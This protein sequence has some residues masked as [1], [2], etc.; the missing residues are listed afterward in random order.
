MIFTVSMIWRKPKDQNSKSDRSLFFHDTS[1]R[2]PNVLINLPTPQTFPINSVHMFCFDDHRIRLS[3]IDNY[4]H[5]QF[6]G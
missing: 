6:V 3:T 4:S 2:H 1:Y 5:E